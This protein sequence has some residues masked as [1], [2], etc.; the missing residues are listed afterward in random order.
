MR[1]TQPDEGAQTAL[2]SPAIPRPVGELLLDALPQLSDRLAEVRLRQSWEAAVGSEVAR[3]T[4]PASLSEGC[5]T[6]VVDNSPWLHELSLRQSELLARIQGRCTA[7]RT[8]R[9]SVGPLAVD[10]GAAARP[11]L[12]P[13]SALSAQDRHEIEDAAAAI[14]DPTLAATARRLLT[15]ARQASAPAGSAR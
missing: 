10:G 3:R 9:L 12:P 7:V 8:L 14:A 1:I 5:L 15:R 2:K 11:Q 4:R 6:I 13:P